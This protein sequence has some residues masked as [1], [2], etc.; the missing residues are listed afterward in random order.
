MAR[1]QSMWTGKFTG[2]RSVAGIVT[3]TV[4][5]TSTTNQT[6]SLGRHPIG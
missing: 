1:I 2:T 3:G 5:T 4:S 6:A